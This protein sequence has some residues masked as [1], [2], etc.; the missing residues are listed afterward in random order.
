PSEASVIGRR[1]VCECTKCPRE[2]TRF[3]KAG[4]DADLRHGK[5]WLLQQ[6][7]RMIHPAGHMVVMWRRAERLLEGAGKMIRAEVDQFC[8]RGQRNLLGEMLL[9]EF[10]YALLLPHRQAATMRRCCG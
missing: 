2:R 4:P 3:A 7:P 8:E 1:H 5:R 6:V 10:H 9:D